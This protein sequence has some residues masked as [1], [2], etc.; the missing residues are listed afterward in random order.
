MLPVYREEL[1]QQ[2]PNF[3]VLTVGDEPSLQLLTSI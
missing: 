3:T 1:W 2:Q